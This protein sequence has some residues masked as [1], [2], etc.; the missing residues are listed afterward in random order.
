M[1]ADS[2]PSQTPTVASMSLSQ[3]RLPPVL[4]KSSPL[5]SGSSTPVSPET[6]TFANS[7]GRRVSDMGKPLPAVNVVEPTTTPTT[8]AA[9]T[10]PARGG[11]ARDLLRQHYG[12]GFGPPA[13]VPGRVDDPMDIGWFASFRCGIETD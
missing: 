7:G 10:R 3:K 1:S 11:K 13:P 5:A 6:A 2:S 8:G 4:T 9:G 12:M